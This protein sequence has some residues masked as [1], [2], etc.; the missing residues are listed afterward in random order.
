MTIS[1]V[2]LAYAA[3]VATLALGISLLLLRAAYPNTLP[4]LGN[5]VSL[6]PSGPP[7]GSP[8]TPITVLTNTGALLDTT[9]LAGRS[10]LLAF[11]SSSCEGCR[12]ALPAMIGYAGRLFGGSG[13]LITVIVGDTR[14]G[15]DI[16][17]ALDGVATVVHE[18]DGG[19]IGIAYRISLFPSY[20]LIS[21]DGT[22]QATGQ[23]VRDLPQSQPQ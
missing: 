10:Y 11:V 19:P 9:E 5:P 6:P 15:L 2:L 18:P 12:A 4:Q 22:V 14:R 20:V 21:D 17:L 3:L 8:A 13:R 23:S 16:A 1:T 7:I